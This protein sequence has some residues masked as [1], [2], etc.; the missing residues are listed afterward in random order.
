MAKD[1]GGSTDWIQD[2]EC[3]KRE[4]RS[5]EELFFSYKYEERHEAKNICFTCP[6]REQC[7]KWALENK[8]I[9]GI[10]GGRDEDEIRRTLSVNVEG[11]EV[12]RSRYPICPFCSANTSKLM[13]KIVEK[14]GGGRWTTMRVVECT[15][16]GFEWR[17]RTSANAVNAYFVEKANK[18]EK[19]KAVVS[20]QPTL[21]EV[22][23][24]AQ[25]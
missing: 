8:E 18:S 20:E 4:Y 12:R 24:D 10:W 21:F 6:V 19:K 7:L 5:K 17:S 25:E 15:A 9:W 14:P 13:S 11:V 1:T 22:P 2:A 16:C 23:K 3:A